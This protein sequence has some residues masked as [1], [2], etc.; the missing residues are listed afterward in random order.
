MHANATET[1]YTA[2][3]LGTAIIGFAMVIGFDI[4]ESL[5]KRRD[6]RDYLERN[7]LI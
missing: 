1:V 3:V 4:A 5:R 2:I 6:H 7:G